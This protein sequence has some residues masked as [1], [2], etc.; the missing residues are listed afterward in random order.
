MRGPPKI[1]KATVGGSD[2]GGGH[3]APAPRG[4][5]NAA[6]PERGGLSAPMVDDEPHVRADVR[7][8]LTA[9][10]LP[11][12][13][14]AGSV[15]GGLAL[16]GEHRP[17]VVLP[18]GTRPVMPGDIRVARLWVVAPAAGVSVM[19]A[20]NNHGIGQFSQQGGAIGDG[21]SAGRAS[22]WPS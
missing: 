20:A 13:G 7:L 11:Q 22:R 2:E 4:R 14:E 12:V 17:S 5:A 18:D 10:G 21:A 1:R 15:A 9:A 16:N 3:T 6:W 19:T 8:R